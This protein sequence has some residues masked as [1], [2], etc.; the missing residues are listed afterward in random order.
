VKKVLYIKSKHS[1]I[2]GF[3]LGGMMGE[4]NKEFTIMV[5]DD[6]FFSLQ[7]IIDELD[8]GDNNFKVVTFDKPEEAC[9]SLEEVDPDMIIS[10]YEMPLLNGVEVCEAVRKNDKYKSIPFVLL[11]GRID[12]D[13]R[14]RAMEIG[15]TDIMLK[16][17]KDH[18]LLKYVEQYAQLQGSSQEVVQDSSEEDVLKGNVLIVA[19]DKLVRRVLKRVFRFDEFKFFEAQDASGAEG[20]L[21]RES[22]DLIFLD[23][24]LSGKNGIDWCREL[25]SAE[26]FKNISIL[27]VTEESND[28][29][30]EF[31]DAGADNVVARAYD[32]KEEIFARTKIQLAPHRGTI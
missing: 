29:G 3:L 28:D 16:P 9:N 23:K 4:G 27:G 15:L 25:R 7:V 17:I 31:M 8:E 20:I 32:Q 21:K 19:E 22:I 5:V 26:E 14:A 13:K 18:A 1:F 11:T 12:D 2:Y 24:E 30:S 10:D 6:N